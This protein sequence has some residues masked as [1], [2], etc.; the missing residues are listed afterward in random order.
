MRMMAILIWLSIILSLHT[1]FLYKADDERDRN[2][3]NLCEKTV[4]NGKF[5]VSVLIW[6]AQQEPIGTQAYE[7]AWEQAESGGRQESMTN[8][9]NEYTFGNG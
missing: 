6:E 2:S 1:L 5:W 8:K 4:S 9:D 7:N 3:P